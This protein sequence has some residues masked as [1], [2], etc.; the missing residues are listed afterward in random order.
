MSEGTLAIWTGPEGV[1]FLSNKHLPGMA[2][3]DISA[4]DTTAPYVAKFVLAT[5]L[6]NMNGVAR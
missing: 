2:L 6:S 3:R 5:T 1:V 4:R